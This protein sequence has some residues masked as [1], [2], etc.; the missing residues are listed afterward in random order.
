MAGY[1]EETDSQAVEWRSIFQRRLSEKPGSP[2]AHAFQPNSHQID[3]FPDSCSS[4][5]RLSTQKKN[6][7][8][9]VRLDLKPRE[10]RELFFEN[11]DDRQHASG[12][13]RVTGDPES[14]ASDFRRVKERNMGRS[15]AEMMMETEIG[16]RHAR[17]PLRVCAI[18]A[19]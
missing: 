19:T 17:S 7:N 18:G 3:S 12:W 4:R 10:K 6:V 5:T 14:K 2:A 15:R 1:C 13:R 16:R 8:A 11:R 9:K